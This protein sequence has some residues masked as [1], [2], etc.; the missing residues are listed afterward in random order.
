MSKFEH[1]QVA[2]GDL[3]GINIGALLFKINIVAS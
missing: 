3:D 1:I 2:A